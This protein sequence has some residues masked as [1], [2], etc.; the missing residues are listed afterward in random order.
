MGEPPEKFNKKGRY[1]LVGVELLVKIKEVI[2][3]IRL[4][5]VVVSRKMVISIGNGVL[6]ANDPNSFSEFAGG[7]TLTDNWARGVLKRSGQFLAEIKF[8]FQRAISTVLYNHDIPVKLV[9]NLD[10]TPLWYVSPGNDTF[11]FKGA[12][13]V[14]TK[15]KQVIGWQASNYCY[16]CNQCNRW[17]FTNAT[18]L[19]W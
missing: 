8:T 9:I 6:K 13:N 11:K 3:G 18:N 2:T 5:R 14:P 17:I 7:I 12:K 10:Q 1:P 4:T 19:S 15:G 16:I